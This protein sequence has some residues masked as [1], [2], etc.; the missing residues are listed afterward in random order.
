MSFYRNWKEF[1]ELTKNKPPRALLVRSM[2]YVIERNAALDLGAGA[3]NDSVY[4][5]NEQFRK[6]TALDREPVAQSIAQTLPKDRFSYVISSVEDFNYTPNTYDLINAQYVL[7]F[8]KNSQIEVVVSKIY[9]ALTS[10]G[11]FTGQIFGERDE[12]ARNATVT[13]RT[14]KQARQLFN[15]FELLVFEEEEQDAQTAAGIMKHWHIFNFI[16]RKK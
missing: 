5:L 6:V 14:E 7:P 9:A 4:L 16:A 8:V 2:P 11:I 3:L 15:P 12:W 13:F 10:G 1:F